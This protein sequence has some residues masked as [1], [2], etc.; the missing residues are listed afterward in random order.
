MRVLLAGASGVIGSRLIPALLELDHEVVGLTRSARSAERIRAS[1]AAA[2]VADVLD[3]DSV[4][5]AVDQ[6]RPEVVLSHLTKLPP[7]LN[8]R[9]M[10][11]AYAA[12]DLVRGQGTANMLAA[13]RGAG[14]RRIVVQNVCF[15]YQPEGGPVKSEDAPLY[16]DGPPHIVRTVKVHEAMEAAVTGAGDIE[17]LVLR[18]GFWY[19]PGTSFASDGYTAEEVRKRRFPVVG[20]GAGLFSFC[21]LDD[22]VAASIAAL[23]GGDPGIYNVCDD[24]PAPVR[25]WLPDYAKALGASPPRRA[26]KW[27]ARLVVGGYTA[28]MMTKLRGA[29]NEKAKR[30][31]G[32]SPR[33]PS[34]RQG[35]RDALG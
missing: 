1:G 6:S 27:L 4:R 33:H 29:S 30:E 28:T 2:V 10:K 11:K 34:W 16:R 7:D 35:F 17:G 14:A 24:Q 3:A 31:L 26:P 20:D 5:A 15:L 23:D 18:F 13:A 8:P 21:H 25:E 32:W 19:G 22:V 12:N 9:N